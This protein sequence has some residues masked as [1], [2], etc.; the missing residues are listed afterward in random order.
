MLETTRKIGKVKIGDFTLESG[1]VIMDAELAFEKA[2]N[3]TGPVILLCHA[4]TGNQ[5]AYGT[6]EHPGWWRGLIG[7][8]CYIDTN[9][10]Q[11]IT[12]NVLGGCSGSTGPTSV[13]EKTGSSYRNTFPF[14][15]VRDMVR[16][17]RQALEV[18]GIPRL[19]AVLGGSLGGMQALEWAVQFPYLIE[20]VFVFAATPYLS[21]YGIAFN[22]IAITAIENDSVY[23]SGKREEGE[24]LVGLEIARMV[25]LLTYR[26]P[27]LFNDRFQREVRER[28]AD[29][30]P[31]FQVDSYLTYQGEKLTRRFDVDSYLTLLYAMNAHDIGN[32]LGG[33]KRAASQ[34]QA[35]V[36]CFGYEGDLLYPPDVMEDFVKHTRYGTFYSIDTDFGHDGFLVE[37]E[38][39]GPIVK[40]ALIQERRLRYGTY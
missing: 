6:K 35:E 25:G 9:H 20:K 37:F 15:T 19:L 17:E 14:V 29:G 39:W 5:Y 33:W 22:R 27:K 31:F 10:Y 40:E 36:Y 2:G 30:K 26:Q 11:V 8:G 13:N 16:A 28:D 3:S 18:L 1:Q 32:K 21:D 24:R 38:K 4:L 34:I 23:K 7:A 12:F